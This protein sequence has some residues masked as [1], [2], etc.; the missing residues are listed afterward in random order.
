[1]PLAV[2]QQTWIHSWLN[3]FVAIFGIFCSIINFLLNQFTEWESFKK[4]R[5]RMNK[6]TGKYWSG[7]RIDR[8][9]DIW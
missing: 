9:R 6:K 5:E 7:S 1:M 4:E 3:V 8:A 2:L